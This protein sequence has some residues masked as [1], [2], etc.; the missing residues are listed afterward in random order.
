AVVDLLWIERVENVDVRRGLAVDA[1]DRARDRVDR[2]GFWRTFVA[3]I[4]ACCQRP[5]SHRRPQDGRKDETHL[6]FQKSPYSARVKRISETLPTEIR[7]SHEVF[8]SYRH[9]PVGRPR[10]GRRDHLAAARDDVLLRL[11]VPVPPRHR[12][13]A[14]PARSTW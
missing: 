9:A 4:A 10:V 13:V 14:G 7:R 8:A 5:G 1:E 3:A 11:A 12:S 6:H 2:P